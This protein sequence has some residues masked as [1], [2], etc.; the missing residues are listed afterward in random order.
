MVLD[1]AEPV[2]E[3]RNDFRLLLVDVP[4]ELGCAAASASHTSPSLSLLS[5]PLLGLELLLLI[6]A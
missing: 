5:E 6:T 4:W 2:M 1:A 3:R